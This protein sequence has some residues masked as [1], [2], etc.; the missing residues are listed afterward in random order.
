MP[1]K[2]RRTRPCRISS[3]STSCAVLLATAKQMPCAPMMIA[4]LMPTTSPCEATSGPP[5]LPGL[6]AASVWITSSIRRPDLRAQ[7][8][9][10][11]GDHARGDGRF[12][13]E[14]IA[15]RDHELAAPQ[16][17]GIAER[18]G[19]QVARG[20]GAQQRQI[21]VGIFA[22]QPRFHDAAFGVGQAE[23]APALDHMAV[24]QHEAVGRD[25]DAGTD[26]AGRPAIAVLLLGLDPHH[27]GADAIGDADHGMGI[28]IEDRGIVGGRIDRTR[29]G[30]LGIEDMSCADIQ[31][32]LLSH[33]VLG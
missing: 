22:E 9:A 15:D 25:D 13:A 30:I 14:R 4:V 21:G 12:K 3:L 2:P 28:G 18:G 10:E 33:G 23:F 1:M 20:I 32:G 5:E 29:A 24:G 26:A 7:R 19:R 16:R 6:S 8:T 27:G 11:R 31:H 17:L